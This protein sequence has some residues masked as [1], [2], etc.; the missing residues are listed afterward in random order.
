MTDTLDVGIPKVQTT[1]GDLVCYSTLPVRVGVGSDAQVLT[2][3][4]ASAAGLKWAAATG[5][6]PSTRLVSAGVGLAGGGDLSADRTFTVAIPQINGF[7]LTLTTAVPVTTADVTGATTIYLSPYKGGMIALYD[8]AAWALYSSAEISVAL[9]TLTSGLPYDVFVLQTAGVLSMELLAWTN[10]TTRAT[11]LVLTNGVWLKT[12]ALTRRYVG[13]FYTTSATATEDSAAKRFL[14]NADNR[15]PR[16]WAPA[17]ETADSWTY[18]T[19]AWRESNANTNNRLQC[20]IGLSEDA[21]HIVARS[22]CFLTSGTSDLFAAGVGVDSTTVN[23][24]QVFGSDVTSTESRWTDEAFYVGTL[25]VG[26]HFLSWLERINNAAVGHTFYGDTG[27]PT[28][29]QCGI[30]GVIVT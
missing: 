17:T 16:P 15:V 4:A 25:A 6:V 26:F 20:V 10:G 24:A 13:T 23:S 9:G 29:K 5:G 18:N 7:R 19:V 3:D 30:V 22:E 1:K 28:I 27:V 21:V 14:F 2:A 8:G 11:A 12:G